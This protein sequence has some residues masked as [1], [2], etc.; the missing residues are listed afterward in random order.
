[1][2]FGVSGIAGSSSRRGRAYSVTLIRALIASLFRLIAFAP[3]AVT[4]AVK[5]ASARR[6]R[7]MPSPGRDS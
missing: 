3:C 2:R 5:C 4:S 1:M 7:R 6:P